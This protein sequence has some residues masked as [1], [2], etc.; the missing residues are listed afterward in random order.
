V[1]LGGR[2]LAC[3][4]LLEECSNIVP[5]GASGVTGVLMIVMARLQIVK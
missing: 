5:I 4:V 3:R 2:V 1:I